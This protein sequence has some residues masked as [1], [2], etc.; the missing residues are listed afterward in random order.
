MIPSVN[1][2]AAVLFAALALVLWVAPAAGTD[3]SIRVPMMWPTVGRVTQPYGCTGFY[4]EPR[5]GNCRHFHLGID[6]ANRSG[7]PIRA[8]ADGVVTHVGWDPWWRGRNRAWTVVISHGH[9]VRT[10]YAHLQQRQIEGIRRGAHVVR[11]Q[12]IGRMG[13]TG[14]ATGPHLHFAVLLYSNWVDPHRFIV[15]ALQH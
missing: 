8:V 3:S 14:H 7:T 6:V 4:A 2:S 11:G 10:F 9:G 12:V 5:R 15:T 13:M 1:R